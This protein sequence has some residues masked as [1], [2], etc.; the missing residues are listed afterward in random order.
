MTRLYNV[1]REPVTY[2]RH[3]LLV[4][5]SGVQVFAPDGRL[6]GRVRSVASARRVVW[7]QRREVQ[8]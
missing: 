8:S 7:N 2:L 3:R 1:P 4:S 6:V 5:Q